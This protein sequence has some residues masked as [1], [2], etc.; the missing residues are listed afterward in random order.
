MIL[1]AIKVSQEGLFDQG[2]FSLMKRTCQ[3]VEIMVHA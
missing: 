3:A 2:A 1:G